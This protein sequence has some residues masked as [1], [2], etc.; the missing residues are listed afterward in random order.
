MAIRLERAGW[1]N[2]DFWMRRQA[3]YELAQA[4]LCEDQI[5]IEPHQ[6]PVLASTNP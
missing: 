4:R 5:T 3:Y 2:A 1:S 6:P